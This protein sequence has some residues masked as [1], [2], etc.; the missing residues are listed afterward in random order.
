MK[1]SEIFCNLPPYTENVC[2][3]LIFLLGFFLFRM[4]F[5]KNNSNLD[6]N[7]KKENFQLT[8]IYLNEYEMENKEFFGVN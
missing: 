7:M 1:N 2:L 5:N 4:I 8:E 6:E 3:A